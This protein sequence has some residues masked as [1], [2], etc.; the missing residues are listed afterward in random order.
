MLDACRRQGRQKPE[1]SCFITPR[2][3]W[4]FGDLESLSNRL[5]Q[6]MLSLGQAGCS[7]TRDHQNARRLW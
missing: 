2:G 4:R 7:A 3:V 6:A 5:A 1:A